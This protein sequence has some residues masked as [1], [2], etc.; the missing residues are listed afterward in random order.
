MYAASFKPTPK[1]IIFP[2]AWRDDYESVVPGYDV[3]KYYVKAAQDIQQQQVG[4]VEQQVEQQVKAVGA[5][6]AEALAVSDD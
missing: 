2:L 5:V 3:T 1:G 6:E 4:Q